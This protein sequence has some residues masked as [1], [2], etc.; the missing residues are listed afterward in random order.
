MEELGIKTTYMRRIEGRGFAPHI[1][2]A[3][4]D[5]IREKLQNIPNALPTDMHR[6]DIA[7]LA[8]SAALQPELQRMMKEQHVAPG[9]LKRAAS[10]RSVEHWDAKTGTELAAR[11]KA[12]LESHRTALPPHLLPVSAIAHALNRSDG[13]VRNA[14]KAAGWEPTPV[15]LRDGPSANCHS[16]ERLQQL[17]SRPA[18]TLKSTLRLRDD[19]AP[20]DFSRLPRDEHDTD[21]DHLAYARALQ[22][23]FFVGNK[24]R[25]GLSPEELAA[26]ESLAATLRIARQEN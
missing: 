16:W 8:G 20:L 1:Q 18:T 23:L 21:P 5:R 14:A 7:K 4:A 17:L 26:A 12:W 11:F 13:T 9:T 10:G 6:Y 19:V 25:L 24:E 2:K 3:G 15:G 22:V